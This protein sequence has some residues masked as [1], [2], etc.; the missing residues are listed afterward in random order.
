MMGDI[1]LGQ[2]YYKILIKLPQYSEDNDVPKIMNIPVFNLRKLCPCAF[3]C[4][5]VCVSIDDKIIFLC[6]ENY[7]FPIH[8]FLIYYQFSQIFLLASLPFNTFFLYLPKQT[9][10]L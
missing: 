2:L 8:F 5:R 6:I 3:V 7:S 1:I 10:I 4:V 9:I